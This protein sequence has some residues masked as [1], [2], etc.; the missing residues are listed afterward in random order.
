MCVGVGVGV[1]VYGLRAFSNSLIVKMGSL[2]S[3]DVTVAMASVDGASSAGKS[4]IIYR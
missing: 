4:T 1:C 3:T 2:I